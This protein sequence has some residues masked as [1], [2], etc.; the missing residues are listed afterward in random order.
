MSR[1]RKRNS[2]MGDAIMA[3]VFLS[4]PF[5]LFQDH[6]LGK[7]LLPFLMI[8]I[9]FVVAVVIVKIMINSLGSASI[10]FPKHRY[11]P[12]SE[13]PWHELQRNKTVEG[14]D[15]YPAW[16]T[17]ND[18]PVLHHKSDSWSLELLKELEWKRFEEVVAEYF[19][20]RGYKSEITALGKDGGIDV[21]VHGKES[22]QPISVVQC[23]AWNT[24][25]VK[26]RE[27]RELLGAVVAH[28]VTQGI[29]ITT[30]V[31]TNDALTFGQEHGLVLIDGGVLK[32][33]EKLGE[34]DARKLLDKATTGEYWIPSCPKCGV[35]MTVRSNRKNNSKFWACTRFPRCWGTLSMQASKY[36]QEKK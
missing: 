14:I 33:I 6:S 19:R 7:A 22:G 28:K 17:T 24:Y 3:M 15:L 8:L 31:F 18:V 12:K 20:L 32:E 25:R 36:S 11:K 35:K 30:S 29:F 2:G 34:G 9:I 16:K 21:I 10:T 26:L 5:A 23:K 4:L 27:V 1:R 13:R